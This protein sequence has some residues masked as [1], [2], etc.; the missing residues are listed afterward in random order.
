MKILEKSQLIYGKGTIF[1]TIL[2]LL[3]RIVEKFNILVLD[4][5]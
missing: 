3:E 1:V 4:E 2:L 5:Y